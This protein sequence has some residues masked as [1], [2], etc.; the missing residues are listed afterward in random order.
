MPS[1]TAEA[2]REQ[3]GNAY[4]NQSGSAGA[5]CLMGDFAGAMTMEKR[6]PIRRGR[7]GRTDT[8]A[9]T[10]CRSRQHTAPAFNIGGVP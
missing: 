5:E 3:P 10:C 7:R 4:K 2:K 9:G 6:G 1:G 8:N